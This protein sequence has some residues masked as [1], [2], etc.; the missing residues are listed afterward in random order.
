MHQESSPEMNAH[1]YTRNAVTSFQAIRY[2]GWGWGK[3]S[4]P[5]MRQETNLHPLILLLHLVTHVYQ[6][7][8]EWLNI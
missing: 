3:S 1:L 2:W 4:K 8:Y 6:Y 5:L 7:K